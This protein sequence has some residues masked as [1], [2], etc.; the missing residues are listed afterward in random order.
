MNSTSGLCVVIV[1]IT[2]NEGAIS[3]RDDALCNVHRVEIDSFSSFRRVNMD[4]QYISTCVSMVEGGEHEGQEGKCGLSEK[5]RYGRGR[6]VAVSAAESFRII[7][8]SHHHSTL[9]C[10]RHRGATPSRELC[11][12][13]TFASFA[14]NALYKLHPAFMTTNACCIAPRYQTTSPLHATSSTCLGAC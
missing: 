9:T 8:S 12:S 10:H 14:V 2:S 5:G 11:L 4:C 7:M 1:V 13:S 3:L 6:S